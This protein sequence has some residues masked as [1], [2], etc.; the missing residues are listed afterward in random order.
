M[1]KSFLHLLTFFQFI[2]IKFETFNSAVLKWFFDHI[3]VHC[4]PWR[5]ANKLTLPYCPVFLLE[6]NIT[7]NGFIKSAENCSRV[8]IT[9][10]L[11]ISYMSMVKCHALG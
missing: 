6:T 11:S 8:F 2:C 4:F 7:Q 5:S 1:K 3:Y 9:G 10:A